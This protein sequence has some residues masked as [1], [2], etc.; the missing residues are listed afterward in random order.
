VDAQLKRR[1]LFPHSVIRFWTWIEN[2]NAF[3][4]EDISHYTEAYYQPGTV[5][6]WLT[7]YRSVWHGASGK[8]YEA[9]RQVV[10]SHSSVNFAW[11]AP[12]KPDIAVPTLLIRGEEDPALPVQ[13]AYRLKRV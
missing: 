11:S 5:E 8:V 2:Q 13:L 3:T 10:F 9:Y 6:A 1:D 4:E 7:L 12:V